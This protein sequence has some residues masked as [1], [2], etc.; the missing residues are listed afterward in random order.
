MKGF[1]RHVNGRVYA[2][3][4]DTFGHITG[5]AGPINPRCLRDL[6]DYDY[7]PGIT[8]WIDHAIAR[9]ELIRINPEKSIIDDGAHRQNT[10]NPLR[11]SHL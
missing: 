9:H 6:D 10:H 3:Q 8:A 11:D 2:V 4:S 1:W 5:A 7:Q